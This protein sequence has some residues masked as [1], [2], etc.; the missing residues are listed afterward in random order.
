MKEKQIQRQVAEFL[1]VANILYTHVPNEMKSLSTLKSN[2]GDNAY[3]ATIEELRQQGTKKGVPDVL[4]FESPPEFPEKKG[5]ALELKTKDRKTTDDQEKWLR[6]LT[7]AG[8][9]C[10]KSFGLEDAFNK[11]EAA[12]YK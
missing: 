9:L 3:F 6:D 5:L 11:L 4:I 10:A 7:K 12:G 1:D 8:W 2:V